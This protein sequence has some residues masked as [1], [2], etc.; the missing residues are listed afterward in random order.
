MSRYS[1]TSTI[2]TYSAVTAAASLI[3]KIPEKI[4]PKTTIGNGT[5]QRASHK[6]A[7]NS[8]KEKTCLGTGCL[9]IAHKHQKYSAA[10][11]NKAGTKPAKYKSVISTVGI[12]SCCDICCAIMPYTNSGT[13]GTNNKPK[14]PEVV[15]KPRLNFSS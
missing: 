7:R 1:S 2:S 13:D 5:S 8:A 15:I 10:I 11:I 14:L 3:T 12:S 6:A 4:P 9:R